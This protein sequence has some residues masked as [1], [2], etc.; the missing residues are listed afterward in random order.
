MPFDVAQLSLLS[1][2]RCARD[3]KFNLCS[4]QL[5]SQRIGNNSSGK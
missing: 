5:R 2:V 1:M 3:R 4:G